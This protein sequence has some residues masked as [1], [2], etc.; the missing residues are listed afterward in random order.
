MSD[1]VTVEVGEEF[2]TIALD[3]G[4]ANVLSAARLAAVNDALDRAEAADQP[5]VVAG[6]EGTFSGGF[7]LGTFEEG[8]DALF[9]MLEAGAKTAERLLAFPRPVVVAC[10]GHAVAMGLFLVLAGD[11][12]VGAAGEF[13]LQANEVEMGLE[14]PRFAVEMVRQRLTP[15]HLSRA[16]IL[17]EPYSPEE[18][19]TAGMLDEVVPAGEVR[20]RARERAAALS[21][22]DFRAHAATKLRVREE[23]LERVR[24]GIE[25]DIDDWQDAYA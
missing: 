23:T 1:A 22:L 14:L 19:V 17:A 9:E 18:A 21:R 7:D 15:A 6:R 20:E 2:S 10:T 13:T 16:T 12:R 3:D 11:E 5:V 4:S 8:G 25:A 24:E